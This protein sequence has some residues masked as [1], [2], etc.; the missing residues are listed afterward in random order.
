[1]DVCVRK[2]LIA[3]CGED[4]YIRIWNY[5]EKI[6]ET[7]RAF[8]TEECFCISIHPSGFQLICGFQDKL[9]MMNIIV[10]NNQIKQY[11]EIPFKVT[12]EN[13]L[14]KKKKNINQI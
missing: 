8:T 6:I 2:P 7:A 5:E 11:N 13:K 4:R 9:K 12:N 3:T 1:M 14:N 10:H